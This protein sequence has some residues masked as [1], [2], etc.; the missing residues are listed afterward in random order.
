MSRSQITNLAFY[1][2]F[3]LLG[4]IGALI[5]ATLQYLAGRYDIPLENAGV[6]T[7]LDFATSTVAVFVVGRW[8]NRFDARVLLVGG[9]VLLCGALLLLAFVPV[10]WVGLAAMLLFGLG[11]GALVVGPNVLVAVFNPHNATSALNLLNVFFGVGAILG[12]QL[13]TL[14][15]RLGDF[16]Y[17]YVIAGG[18]LLL[19]VPMLWQVNYRP[20]DAQASGGGGAPAAVPW[21]LMMPFAA[22]LFMYVGAEVGFSSWITTQMRLVALAR[23]EVAAVAVSIF[24]AGL[25]A[26]RGGGDPHRAAHPRRTA[27]D[28]F[29]AGHGHRDGAGAAVPAKPGDGAGGRV[30]HRVRLWSGLPDDAGRRQPAVSGRVRRGLRRDHRHRQSRRGGAPLVPGAGGRRGRWRADRRAGAERDDAGRHAGDPGAG[31]RPSAGTQGNVSVGCVRLWR[32][33]MS[34]STTAWT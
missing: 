29:D 18:L 14:A 13:L 10:Q 30:R 33:G 28:G 16:T 27:P 17:A 9:P 15:L 34:A 6:F 8:Y 23:P 32:K 31:T 4:M 26:G 25:T 1:A 24:W 19:L 5:G 2:S 21:A 20:Q 3:L 12:P 11:Y 22:L 7:S